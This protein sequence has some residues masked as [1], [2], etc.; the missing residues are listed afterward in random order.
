MFARADYPT[1][2]AIYAWLG[3]LTYDLNNNK[4]TFTLWHRVN[5]KTLALHSPTRIKLC[6]T[7]LWRSRLC[8][9]LCLCSVAHFKIRHFTS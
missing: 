2:S 6:N 8:W 5:I 3:S 9:L 1:P 7:S 4:Y